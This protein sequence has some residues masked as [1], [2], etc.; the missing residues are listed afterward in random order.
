MRHFF[1]HPIPEAIDAAYLKKPG[2]KAEKVFENRN[3]RILYKLLLG[4]IPLDPNQY[5]FY[6]FCTR[7]YAFENKKAL[8]KSYC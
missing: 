5:N 6:I 4:N 7:N 2:S 3:F 8:H 1:G